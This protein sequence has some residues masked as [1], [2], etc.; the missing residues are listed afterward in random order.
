MNMKITKDFAGL[1]D[2]GWA[3]KFE[4]SIETAEGLVIE[5]DNW[6]YVTGHIKAGE[7]IEAG[8]SIVCKTFLSF[9]YN[10]FAGTATWKT[11]APE[12]SEVRCK[13]LAGSGEIKYGTLVLSKSEGDEKPKAEPVYHDTHC[14]QFSD[15]KRAC[16][17]GMDEKGQPKAESGVAIMG[18][19]GTGIATS[20]S[21]KPARAREI[22]A[23]GTQRMIRE[24]EALAKSRRVVRCE[25][26]EALA[27]GMVREQRRRRR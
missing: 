11:T 19:D 25:H 9:E 26:L 24:S 2:I 27:P 18:P 22:T 10:L 7:G 1:I 6:L 17:C 3:Y 21:A 15:P 14:P 20:A 5:L 4:G 16:D 8:L 23:S 13:R 12:E